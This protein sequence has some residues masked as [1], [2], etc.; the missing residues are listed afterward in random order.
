[1]REEITRR[2]FLKKTGAILGLAALEQMGVSEANAEPK[3]DT[4]TG[5][6]EKEKNTSLAYKL[7]EI[8]AQKAI[9][10]GV[11]EAVFDRGDYK[12]HG[13]VKAVA[14]G[15]RKKGLQL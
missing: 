10:K 6:K 5:G 15:A 3:I 12:Y 9:E 14:E 11:K 8:I 7:G 13:R 4:A 1:M 2:N